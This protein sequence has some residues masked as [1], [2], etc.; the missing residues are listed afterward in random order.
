MPAVTVMKTP[1]AETNMTDPQHDSVDPTSDV[2]IILNEDEASHVF[3][4]SQVVVKEIIEEQ[5]KLYLKGDGHKTFLRDGTLQAISRDT[6]FF[7]RHLSLQ[8]G[9]MVSI[10]NIYFDFNTT[11][12]DDKDK[13]A[14]Q[15]VASL[16]E[17]YPHLHVYVNAHAD[18]RGSESYNF[19]LSKRRA[20][21]V[22]QFV[23]KSGINESRITRNSFGE[24]QP[25][26][27]CLSCTEDQ[28]MLNRRAEFTFSMSKSTSSTG[29]G[30]SNYETLLDQY[31]DRTIPSVEFKVTIGVFKRQHNL[32]FLELQDIGS[33]ESKTANGITYYYLAPFNSLRS[34]EHA[35]KQVI[36]RGIKDAAIRIEYNGK[37]ITLAQFIQLANP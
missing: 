2:V 4:V 20:K 24:T 31:G 7:Q 35:R 37:A 11:M 33:V 15:N 9:N 36:D 1:S 23:E 6:A 17:K 21:A 10:N 30:Q 29:N 5:H 18:D 19:S 28:H 14:I 8:P 3:I 32:Q 22:A 16:L 26:T 12:L 34:A 25:A 27:T 13:Q